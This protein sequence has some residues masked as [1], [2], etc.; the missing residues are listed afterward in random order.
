MQATE[1]I[2]DTENPGDLQEVTPNEARSGKYIFFFLSWRNDNRVRNREEEI[3]SVLRTN[4]VS[5]RSFRF[6]WDWWLECQSFNTGNGL[7]FKEKLIRKLK[8]KNSEPYTR[9]AEQIKILEER[10]EEQGS[11]IKT[12]EM[13]KERMSRLEQFKI[14]KSHVFIF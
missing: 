11:S 1:Y 9:T 4:L 13:V 7:I 10:K 8:P 2:S 6:D 14:F 3:N 5:T 12:E